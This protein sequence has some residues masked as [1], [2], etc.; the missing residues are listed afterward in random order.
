L[1]NRYPIDWEVV[2]GV[3]WLENLRRKAAA[4]IVFDEVKLGYGLNSAEAWAMKMPALVGL[5]DPGAR[6]MF[7][8]N[9]GGFPYPDTTEDTIEERLEELIVSEEARKHWAEVGYQF[10]QAHHAESVVAPQAV[11]LY[12][13]ILAG[14]N[15]KAG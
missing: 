13:R 8:D 11:A 10:V 14:R 5:V 1:E 7:M 12:E 2:E 4:D 9:Y 6:Q 15:G 3:P